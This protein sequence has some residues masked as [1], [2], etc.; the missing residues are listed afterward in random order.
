MVLKGLNS[1]GEIKYTIHKLISWN[2][3]FFFNFIESKDHKLGMER[4]HWPRDM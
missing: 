1:Q 2:K 3:V 4:K